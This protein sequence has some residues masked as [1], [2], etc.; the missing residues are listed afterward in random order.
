MGRI[1]CWLG[2]HDWRSLAAAKGS[3]YCVRPFCTAIKVAPK[4]EG[5]K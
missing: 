5:R 4:K 1:L 3:L 2:F